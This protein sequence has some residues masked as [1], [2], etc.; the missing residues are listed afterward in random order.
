MQRD[1]DL[2]LLDLHFTRRTA[3]TLKSLDPSLE[4]CAEGTCLA[5]K[6]FQSLSIALRRG[7]VCIVK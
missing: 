1:T 5:D 2:L 6:F 4:S 7:I 3:L